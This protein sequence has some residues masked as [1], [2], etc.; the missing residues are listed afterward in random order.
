M[1]WRI[2]TG[3]AARF[4]RHTARPSRVSVLTAVWRHCHG[5]LYVCTYT[6]FPTPP[7]VPLPGPLTGMAGRF[8]PIKTSHA[9]DGENNVLHCVPTLHCWFGFVR[10]TVAARRGWQAPTAASKGKM[11]RT[12]RSGGS[13]SLPVDP[14]DPNQM[15]PRILTLGL[16]AKLM[17]KPCGLR[18][19]EAYPCI[20]VSLLCACCHCRSMYVSHRVM[21]LRLTACLLVTRLLYSCCLLAC[22]ILY[23]SCMPYH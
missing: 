13:I 8:L 5:I 16:E 17:Q 4:Y 23:V 12:R 6:S 19:S 15:P 10:Y 7:I 18:P 2:C 21:L 1:L 9:I 20:L 3:E 22:L 14:L 11:K